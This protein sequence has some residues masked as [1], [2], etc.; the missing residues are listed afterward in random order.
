MLNVQLQ[1]SGINL[2]LCTTGLCW[3]RTTILC[4]YAP[5]FK[6]N[7]D[8]LPTAY[9]SLSVVRVCMSDTTSAARPFNTDISPVFEQW[10][11]STGVQHTVMHLKINKR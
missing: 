6:T 3:K 2:A 10:L 8:C 1:K 4:L 7:F 9:T 11:T 5:T